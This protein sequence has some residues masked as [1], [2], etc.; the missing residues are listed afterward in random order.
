MGAEKKSE[1]SL[2]SKLREIGPSRAVTRFFQKYGNVRTKATYAV[3]LALYLRWLKSRGVTMGPD[4]LVQDNLIC[5][6]KSDA[7]VVETKRR[8]TDWLNDYVNGYMMEKEFSESKRLCAAAA[9]K[10]LYKANDSILFGDFTTAEQRLEPPARPLFSADIRKVLGIMPVGSRAP[11]L[12]TWQS[13][14]EIN[15]ILG[16]K[17]PLGVPPVKVDLFGRKGHRRAYWSY[18]GA[19]STAPMNA[20]THHVTKRLKAQFGRITARTIEAAANPVRRDPSCL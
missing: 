14:I 8:H 15:R 10:G 17:F 16:M 13:G 4:A 18:I 5:V 1:Q 20:P 7:V 12:I 11:L 9:I 19:D 2:A 6:F 3:E